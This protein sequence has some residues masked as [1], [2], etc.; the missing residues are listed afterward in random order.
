MGWKPDYNITPR[1]IVC[2]ALKHKDGAMVIG[3]RHYD[4]IMHNTLDLRKRLNPNEDWTES[5][6]GFI[7]QFGDFINRV[8]SWL[9]ACQT[10]QVICLVGNQTKEDFGKP[11]VKLYSENLY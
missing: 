1:R 11:N 5:D 8:D 2:A 3:A 6:E 10:N 7:D 9:I 4:S